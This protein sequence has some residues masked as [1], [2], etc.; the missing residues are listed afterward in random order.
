MGD[1]EDQRS[2]T[3]S[4]S[5][6]QTIHNTRSAVD[7]IYFERIMKPNT[8]PFLNRSSAFSNKFDLLDKMLNQLTPYLTFEEVDKLL[9]DMEIRTKSKIEGNWTMGDCIDFC[10]QSLGSDRYDILRNLWIMD[11]QGMIANHNKPE[12]LR[13]IWIHKLTLQEAPEWIALAKPD[14][15][16]Q[17]KVPKL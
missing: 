8:N 4:H 13:E 2:Q 10:K 11:N 17:L 1:T 7:C 9:V 5:C 15:Y 16:T 3:T 6:L 12:E 14:Q